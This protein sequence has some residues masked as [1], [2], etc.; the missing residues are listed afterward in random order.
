MKCTQAKE[1]FSASLDKDLTFEE[2]SLLDGHLGVCPECA[3]EMS[4]MTRLRDFMQQMPEMDPGADFFDRIKDRID[5]AGNRNIPIME[6]AAFS[7]MDSLRD[8]WQ[9]AW[10]RPAMGAAFGLV[11]GILISTGQGGIGQNGFQTPSMAINSAGNEDLAAFAMASS[12]PFDEIEL[13]PLRSGADSLQMNEEYV[14]DPY[15]Q[16]P[17]RGLVQ[18]GDIGGQQVSSG[19]DSQGAVKIIF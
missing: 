17:T 19:R 13:P 11:L 4:K 14:L 8:I 10:L 3:A 1:L 6:P 5:E 16:D 12:G 9:G 15:K 7:L 2:Q 18:M